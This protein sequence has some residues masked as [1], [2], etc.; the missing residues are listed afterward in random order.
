MSRRGRDIGVPGSLRGRLI[1]AENQSATT[2]VPLNR[3]KIGPKLHK[4]SRHAARA[5][6]ATAF[7]DRLVSAAAL[8]E[9]AGLEC[10][11]RLSSEF[12]RK[13]SSTSGVASRFTISK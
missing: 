11:E 7:D 5:R 9:L 13:L 1:N 10:A 3:A 12:S 8:E 6:P 4:S 2:V